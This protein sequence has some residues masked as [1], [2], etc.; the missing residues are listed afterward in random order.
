MTLQ[1]VVRGVKHVETTE[2]TLLNNSVG[3][4][5]GVVLESAIEVPIG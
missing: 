1:C 3:T 2:C 5:L 4:T